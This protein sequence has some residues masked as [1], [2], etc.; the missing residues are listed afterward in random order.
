M[1]KQ[2]Y[3]NV[4]IEG[5]NLIITNVSREK[6]LIRSVIIRYFI[7]VENPIE[8]RQFKRTVSEEKEINSWLEPDRFLKIPLT[9][10]DI[11]EVSIVFSTGLITLRQDI[12]I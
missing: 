8:E 3:I 4:K 10:S 9:I 7:T 11:K 1:Q 2:N 5:G 12:E 6:I